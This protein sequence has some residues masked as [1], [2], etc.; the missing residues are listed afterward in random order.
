VALLPPLPRG[1]ERVVFGAQVLVVD[2]TMQKIPDII[3]ILS[4]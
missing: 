3:Y 2:G 4:P 1:R